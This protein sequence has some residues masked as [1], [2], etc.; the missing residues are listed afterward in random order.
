MVC[1]LCLCCFASRDDTLQDSSNPIIH[2]AWS[3]GYSPHAGRPV[4]RHHCAPPSVFSPRRC[5]FPESSF[6]IEE[7]TQVT[8]LSHSHNHRSAFWKSSSC[9]CSSL[10]PLYF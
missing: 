6:V 10:C 1:V 5:A 9:F 2:R 7:H 3:A 4:G 8:L